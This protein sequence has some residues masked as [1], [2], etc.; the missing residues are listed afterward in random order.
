[1]QLIRGRGGR[2]TSGTGMVGTGEVILSKLRMMLAWRQ[3]LVLGLRVKELPSFLVFNATPHLFFP[4]HYSSVFRYFQQLLLSCVSALTSTFPSTA[5]ISTWTS[6]YVEA[7][8]V[9]TQS[10]PSPTHWNRTQ[11][12]STYS[13]VSTKLNFKRAMQKG[14]GEGALGKRGV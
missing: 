9:L 5:V 13:Y 8:P 7:T 6:R 12:S 10:S 1:M 14:R 11:Q 2:R 3:C 4:I